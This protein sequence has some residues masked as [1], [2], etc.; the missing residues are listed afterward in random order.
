MVLKVLCPDCGEITVLPSTVTAVTY[1]SLGSHYMFRCA[2]CD[3]WISK[4]ADTKTLELLAEAGIRPRL[5]LPSPRPTINGEVPSGP[6]LTNQ[7]RLDLMIDLARI[8][9]PVAELR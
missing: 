9:D 2:D 1:G 3:Q 7:D 8:S 6:V 5:V 4:P